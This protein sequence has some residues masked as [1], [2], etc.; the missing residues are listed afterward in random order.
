[1][2]DEQCAAGM[3]NRAGAVQHQVADVT[4]CRLSGKEEA[5]QRF[6][7]VEGLNPLLKTRNVGDDD[8]P[9]A[10]DVEPRRLNDATFLAADLDDLLCAGSCG[11]DAVDG[12]PSPIEHVVGAVRRLLKADRVL[13]RADDVR[14]NA[15]DRAKDFARMAAVARQPGSRQSEKARCCESRDE[16]LNTECARRLLPSPKPSRAPSRPRAGAELRA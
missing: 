6:L 14:W 5:G 10:R 8:V 12:L 9:I 7:S 15:A 11:V 4:R 3:L 13:E 16:Q 1:M 2:T